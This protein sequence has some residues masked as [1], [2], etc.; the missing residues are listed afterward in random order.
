MDPGSPG[1]GDPQR[2]WEREPPD[3]SSFDLGMGAAAVVVSFGSWIIN[4]GR[5]FASKRE[6][7]WCLRKGIPWR[8]ERGPQPLPP[9]PWVW[10][11]QLGHGDPWISRERDSWW[12]AKGAATAVL[13]GPLNPG[14]QSRGDP[15]PFPICWGSRWRGPLVCGRG[16]PCPFLLAL[17]MGLQPW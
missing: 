9:F 15:H 10:E 16:V 4:K 3:P 5:P 7:L 12:G 13:A 14:S 11:L 8:L 2:C 1:G 17:G 6:D